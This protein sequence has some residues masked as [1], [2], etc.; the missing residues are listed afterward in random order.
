MKKISILENYQLDKLFN[1]FNS[2]KGEEFE[3]NMFNLIKKKYKNKGHGYA[4][5]YEKYFKN[6][7]DLPIKILEIG[8]FHGMHQRDFFILKKLKFIVGY[9]PDLFRY[10]SKIRKFLC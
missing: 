4:R 2:D 7:K 9:F 6:L 3:D 8:S 5:F 1:H 10:M